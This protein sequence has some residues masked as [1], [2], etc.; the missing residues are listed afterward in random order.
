MVCQAL[1]HIPDCAGIVNYYTE[2]SYGSEE[3]FIKIHIKVKEESAE[4]MTAFHNAAH[5]AFETDI[6][7]MS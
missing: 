2:H 6:G 5:G 7:F 3:A 4:N 1:D